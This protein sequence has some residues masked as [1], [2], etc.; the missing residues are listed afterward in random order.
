[1]R[2]RN[3]W[4][5]SR[6]YS[7]WASQSVTIVDC[8]CIRVLALVASDVGAVKRTRCVLSEACYVASLSLDGYRW[9]T[10]DDTC[11]ETLSSPQIPQISCWVTDATVQPISNCCDHPGSAIKSVTGTLIFRSAVVMT[12]LHET[13]HIAARRVTTRA[14][15]LV[16]NS[17]QCLPSVLGAR[18]GLPRM[19][20]PSHHACPDSLCSQQ[21]DRYARQQM[22]CWSQFAMCSRHRLRSGSQP[23]HSHLQ[24]L[25]PLAH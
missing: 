12:P 23:Q 16:Q 19:P 4:R 18:V 1:V 3:S 6:R 11:N 21:S 13:T 2:C 8:Q 25:G 9:S 24:R 15:R 14:V 5:L 7:R 20:S 10:V 22:H 17:L